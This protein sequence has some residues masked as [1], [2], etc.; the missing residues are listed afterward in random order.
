MLREKVQCVRNTGSD[1]RNGGADEVYPLVGNATNPWAD[2]K[3]VAGP[4]PTEF[5]MYVDARITCAVA[6]FARHQSQRCSVGG[7]IQINFL[8]SN[9]RGTR[10]DSGHGVLLRVLDGCDK[11]SRRNS[12]RILELNERKMKG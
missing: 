7:K 12:C 9:A 10:C 11:K 1:E 4:A 2:V 8:A 3:P 5:R 6:R